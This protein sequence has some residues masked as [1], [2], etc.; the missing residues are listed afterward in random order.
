MISDT[1]IGEWTF[2]IK[3]EE[4]PWIA[5]RRFYQTQRGAMLGSYEYITTEL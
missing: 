1:T 2:S 5:S 3:V 4:E